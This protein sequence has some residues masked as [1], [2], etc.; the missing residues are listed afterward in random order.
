MFLPRLPW[1]K[2]YSKTHLKDDGFAGLTTAVML[3]PQAMAY[4]IL[5]GLP[6]Q[7]GLYASI[8]P[9]FVYAF[10]GSSR[11]LAI[12]PVAMDSILSAVAV[13]AVV[14]THP[15][16][17]ESDKIVSCS[18]GI[19]VGAILFLMGVLRLGRFVAIFTPTI[20]SAFTSAAALIIGINPKVNFGCGVGAHL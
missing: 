11:A 13:G 20:I 9:V 10:L 3:V 14:S 8:I 4:A 18:S 19:T 6:P 5:A 7:V 16:L 12:G 2:G 1:A 15:E 17:T